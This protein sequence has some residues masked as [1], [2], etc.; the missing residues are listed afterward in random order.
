MAG[1]ILTELVKSKNNLADENFNFQSILSQF[2]P[3]VILILN[4]SKPAV[5]ASEASV[6]AALC[7][8]TRFYLDEI[9]IKLM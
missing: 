6:G 1:C 9:G 7:F 8:K 4:P 5:P 3:D 2:Y